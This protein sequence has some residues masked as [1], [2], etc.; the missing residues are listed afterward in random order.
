MSAI[1]IQYLGSDFTAQ[2]MIATVTVFLALSGQYIT[3]ILRYAWAG[4][5]G[6]DSYDGEHE[7]HETLPLAHG[8]EQN[9]YGTQVSRRAQNPLQ[10]NHQELN[11]STHAI[12]LYNQQDAGVRTIIR[13]HESG[14][15]LAKGF[16][17]D[18]KEGFSPSKASFMAFVI[19]SVFAVFVALILAQFFSAKIA[20]DRAGLY[21]S[22]ECG[23][24]DFDRE[25]AADDEI[26]RADLLN[27]PKE[28]RAGQYARNCYNTSAESAESDKMGCGFFYQP[29]MDFERKRQQA[30]PFLPSK[31]CSGDLYSAVA[32]DT[33]YVSIDAIGIN[34]EKDYRFRRRTVCSPLNMSEQY[35][36]QV[37]SNDL[38]TTGYEYYYGSTDDAAYTF[39]TTGDSF[40][41]YVPMY[42][43]K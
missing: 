31:M 20:T 33:G 7:E 29:N 42:S 12:Q 13:Q 11:E 15:E 40:L 19:A 10:T 43:V 26:Y 8:E 4:S 25:N 24:W 2:V 22:T 34:T 18:L 36:K 9:E 32:F 3:K 27:A 38:N 16:W 30:C 37:K 5:T 39:S 35:I 1:G 41:W 23:I 28:A 17:H 21:S 14:R 6:Q